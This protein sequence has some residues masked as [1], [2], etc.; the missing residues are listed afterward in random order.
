MK[1]SIKTFTVMLA[2][3]IFGIIIVNAATINKTDKCSPNLIVSMTSFPK[4]FSAL[5]RSLKTIKEQ[6]VQPDKLILYLSREECTEGVP[7]EI[8]EYVE[9][10]YI[11]DVLSKNSDKIKWDGQVLRSYGKLIPALLEYPNDIIITFCIEV[12]T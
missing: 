7:R 2:A 1:R 8:E 3:F 9:I 12:K 10:H 6:S 11:E 4:R 5:M